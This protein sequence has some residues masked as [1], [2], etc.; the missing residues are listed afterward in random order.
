VQAIQT[1]EREDA[2]SP[3][4]DVVGMG[5]QY[6][7]DLLASNLIVRVQ[8][9]GFNGTRGDG[10]PLGAAF[11]SIS[12]HCEELKDVLEGHL[13]TVCPMGVPVLEMGSE[14]DGGT[15]SNEE[16][17]WMES[18]GMIREKSGEFESFDRFLHRTEVCFFHSLSLLALT[19]YHC[20]CLTSIVC[21]TGSNICNGKHHVFIAIQPHTPWR[22]RRCIN[23]ARAIPRPVTS[24]ALHPTPI[25]DRSR[26][27]SL[28]HRGG[29]HAR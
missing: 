10:F 23:L 11:A 13:Y 9:D 8:A 27:R 7:L 6:L 19:Y 22:A 1:A 17:K 18:L 14:G 25:T 4:N 26:P 12:L 20:E 21:L 29:S 2:S 16:E 15:G 24:T 3:P 5:K 28:S